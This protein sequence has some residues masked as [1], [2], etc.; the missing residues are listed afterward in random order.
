MLNFCLGV[1]VGVNFGLILF[2]IISAGKSA[3]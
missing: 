3:K 1:V 2:G